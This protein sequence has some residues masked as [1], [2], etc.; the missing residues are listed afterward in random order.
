LST[1]KLFHIDGTAREKYVPKNYV[2]Q[3]QLD[4]DEVLN[5]GFKILNDKTLIK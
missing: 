1:A 4:S 3:T 5:Y 2:T